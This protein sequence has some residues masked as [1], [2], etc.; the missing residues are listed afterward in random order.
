M[1]QVTRGLPIL[2]TREI[3]GHYTA[4]TPGRTSVSPGPKSIGLNFQV[5]LR[6]EAGKEAIAVVVL[7]AEMA[8]MV[9][10]HESAWDEAD[11]ALHFARSTARPGGVVTE[12]ARAGRQR[13]EFAAEPTV[14]AEH[15]SAADHRPVV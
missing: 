10:M 12:P 5:Y 2:S 4:K 7:P 11:L 1:T 3:S 15:V 8:A 6:I 13:I 9:Q 14:G